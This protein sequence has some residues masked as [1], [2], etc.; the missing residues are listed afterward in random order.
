M[1]LKLSSVSPFVLI[2]LSL[3]VACINTPGK[4]LVQT[5]EP[6]PTKIESGNPRSFIVKNKVR[7]CTETICFIGSE[8][9]C[10]GYYEEYDTRG[11]VTLSHLRRMG[12]ANKY[13]YDENDNCIMD[14]WD[15]GPDDCD[16]VMHVFDDSNQLIKEVNPSTSGTTFK[17]DYNDEGRLVRTVSE[18]EN[19]E[20]NIVV[21]TL[22]RTWTSF[23]KM[24]KTNRT[25][26]I[27][28]ENGQTKFQK[29]KEKLEECEYDQNGNL[30][31]IFYYE[32]DTVA[33][34]VTFKYDQ[35]NRLVEK[36]E[37]DPER[38]RYSN[39]LKDKDSGNNGYFKTSIEYAPDGRI[40]ALYSYFSDPCMSL[41]NHF[42]CKYHYLPNGLVEHLD[43]YEEGV[44]TLIAKFEYTFY[45]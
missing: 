14:I 24:S 22:E 8:G 1:I 42:L 30:I 26:E 11:N 29:Q 39:P 19:A 43:V 34:K 9:S 45:D 15:S 38:A 3:S 12:T 36:I 6:D 10:S 13:V 23:G 41:E 27:H 21:E 4:T 33:K 35:Q 40:A 28:E 7:S 37:V 44:L 20:G 17:Y 5:N 32:A 18:S 31:G 16:T 25:I 2:T